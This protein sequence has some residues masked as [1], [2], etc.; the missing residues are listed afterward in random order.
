MRDAF[1]LMI[2][3][4]ITPTTDRLQ[5]DLD[6]SSKYFGEHV[7]PTDVHLDTRRRNY[8]MVQRKLS[9]PEAI[10]PQHLQAEESVREE[11]ADIVEANRLLFGQKG[12]Y[13]DMMGWNLHNIRTMAAA[14]ENVV[15]VP[16]ENGNVRLRLL[17]IA[18]YKPDFSVLGIYF[19]TILAVQ[20][21][22]MLRFG[23]KFV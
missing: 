3:N 21:A 2:G 7:V 18:L 9:S 16:H 6:L 15:K 14:L 13:L 19:H 17:D 22:N 5:S 20:K 1:S 10:T 4:L 23:M 11:L 12:L 8:C